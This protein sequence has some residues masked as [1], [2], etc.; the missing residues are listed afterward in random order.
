MYNLTTTISKGILARINKR[1]SS[2]PCQQLCFGTS[3]NSENWIRWWPTRNVML[4]GIHVYFTNVKYF[5]CKSN[6]VNLPWEDC[7]GYVYICWFLVSKWMFDIWQKLPVGCVSI[8]TLSY[9]FHNYSNLT[10]GEIWEHGILLALYQSTW[11]TIT[12]KF[13]TITWN[14][15]FISS[16]IFSVTVVDQNNY[17]MPTF[18]EYMIYGTIQAISKEAKLCN[19]S[20][21]I[22]LNR[23][24]LIS[25]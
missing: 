23:S 2:K 19:I 18:E 4:N 9:L 16:E 25:C 6:Y 12:Y 22:K 1:A 10:L 13:I 21:T 3:T 15:V 14:C 24:A 20:L 5:I 7:L 17:W 11:F 8:R